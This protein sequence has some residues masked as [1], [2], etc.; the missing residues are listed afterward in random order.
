[1]VFEERE[2][3]GVG[4]RLVRAYHSANTICTKT[5]TTYIKVTVP[6]ATI[7]AA[8]VFGNVLFQGYIV[9]QNRHVPCSSF[10]LVYPPPPSPSYPEIFKI[11]ELDC[12][13]HY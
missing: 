2:Q 9:S 10:F 13:W 4:I 11:R 5:Y 6:A 7:L 1:M 8:D 12:K 3:D